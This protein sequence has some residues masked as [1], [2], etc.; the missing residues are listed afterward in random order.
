M[1]YKRVSCQLMNWFKPDTKSSVKG[2]K[3]I[4]PV[5]DS[6]FHHRFTYFCLLRGVMLATEPFSGDSFYDYWR[7]QLKLLILDVQTFTTVLLNVLIYI[8]D[9]PVLVC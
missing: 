1:L 8:Y 4:F 2:K 9:F 6:I 7:I 5:S 3:Q